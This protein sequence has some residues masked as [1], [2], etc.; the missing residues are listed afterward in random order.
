MNIA[1]NVGELNRTPILI[2]ERYDHR[3]IQMKNYISRK[4]QRCVEIG[5]GWTLCHHTCSYYYRQ[6]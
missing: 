2:A 5:H 1:N 3:S 6:C 4:R